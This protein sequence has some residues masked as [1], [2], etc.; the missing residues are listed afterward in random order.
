MKRD[1]GLIH[2]YNVSDTGKKRDEIQCS[3]IFSVDV[4]ADTPVW[5]FSMAAR[6]PDKGRAED[7]MIP[8]ERWPTKV[9]DYCNWALKH[10]MPT[11]DGSRQVYMDRQVYS[12]HFRME[13]TPHEQ[14]F[15]VGGPAGA[16]TLDDIEPEIIEELKE[17]QSKWH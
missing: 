11:A 13:M 7:R 12:I 14:K 1:P 4:E 8:L 6:W 16:R 10:C 5:H 17:K 3:T 2:T 9:V 15:I